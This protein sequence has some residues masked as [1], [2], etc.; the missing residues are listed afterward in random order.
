VRRILLPTCLLALIGCPSRATDSPDAELPEP[1]IAKRVPKLLE[2]HGHERVDDYYWLRERDDPEVLAYLEA[3]N[4]YTKA[5]TTHT[6]A[7]R[8]T[9]EREMAGRIQQ[10]DRSVP[11]RERDYLYYS[12]WQQGADYPIHARKPVDS[13]EG[14]EQIVLD[15]EA[16]AEGHDYFETGDLELSENQQ[17]LA[18]AVDTVGR[19]IHTI[20]FI[21]LRTGERLPDRI[22]EVAGELAWA[23]DDRTLFYVRQ[24]PVTLREHRIYRHTLG[25]DPARDELV[26]EEKDPTFGVGLWKTKSR[27][28][29]I[30]ESS[31]TLSS[32]VRLIDADDPS[33]PPR[34]FQ[35][36]RRG[37]E[38]DV[39]HLGERFYV[40]TN[41]DAVNFRLMQ[42]PLD[43]TEASHWR[44]VVGHEPDSLFE[45][46]EVFAEHLVLA[47]RRAGLIE[48]DVVP[49]AGGEP[50]TI[51]FGEPAYVAWMSDNHQLDSTT[52]RY[53]YASLTTPDSVF[54]YELDTRKSTLL[55]Q[56]E[57][58][59]GFD[60][61]N[62]VTERLSAP[63]DDGA[64]V[65]ISLV[66][67]RDTPVDGS[68]PLLLEGYGAYGGSFD[69]EFD[70]EVLSLLDRGF[71][72]A[73]AHVRGGE[74]LGRAWYEGGRLL[75]K[76]NTFTDFID[77][78]EHLI[79]E[80]HADPERVFAT[81]ASAGGLLVGA[82]VNMRPD[83]FAGAIAGVP[84][85]DVVTTMLDES[86]PLTTFEFDEWGNP[87]D[88]TYYEYMLSYSPYDN[89]S[90]QDYPAL[91]VTAGLHDS[92]V[93]Y[94]EPAKWVAKLRAH[95][96]GDD[97]LLLRTDMSAGHGGQAGRLESLE[98]T[99]FEYAFLLDLAGVQD[100][101]PTSNT[102]SK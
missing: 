82:V 102:R 47:K 53:E 95:K 67:R 74:E 94:W 11:A 86:I 61:N 69:P 16:L 14:P 28:F 81:G 85:V 96:T 51:D 41:L 17:I 65:P 15:V 63:A 20:E 25:E 59:G 18:Y 98:Q 6:A 31:H 100:P 56:T 60:S 36:R 55:K 97:L 19:R 49:L 66:R 34:I 8:A 48:F 72:Y 37:V 71:V 52:L 33:A 64:A 68:A 83:L 75:N 23:N 10:D 21:D 12:R 93:Q 13:P 87:T 57:V 45:G 70:A 32:E 92:Q 2:L 50:H 4:E 58:L 79:A 40:R 99:A 39:D 42:T 30:I 88:R 78:A 43:A 76:R 5:M 7:L 54:D 101:S 1:P 27:R 22:D 29:L 77:C 9:L 80:R 24:D 90:A 26:Y 91:L 38:Y 84:F 35:A 62:Y 44:E 46:F 89:V 73:I 3:E